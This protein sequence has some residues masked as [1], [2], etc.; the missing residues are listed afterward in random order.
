MKIRS[1]TL[2]VLGIVVLTLAAYFAWP[3][4]TID[5]KPESKFVPMAAATPRRERVQTP[6][7]SN[8]KPTKAVKPVKVSF[9]LKASFTPNPANAEGN[10]ETV[11][12]EANR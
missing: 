10:T 2:P 11:A 7:T 12:A 1:L 9:G 3:K 6:I 4:L 8:N 5:S